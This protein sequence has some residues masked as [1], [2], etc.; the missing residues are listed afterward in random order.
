MPPDLK[1][2]DREYRLQLEA[3]LRRAVQ[4]GLAAARR[5]EH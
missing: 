3:R 4:Q 1:D 2:G 5:E